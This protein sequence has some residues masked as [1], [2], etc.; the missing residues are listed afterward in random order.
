[1]GT[2]TVGGGRAHDLQVLTL[3]TV[4]TGEFKEH[5]HFISNTLSGVHCLQS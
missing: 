2:G 4:V 5:A 3:C 1:M